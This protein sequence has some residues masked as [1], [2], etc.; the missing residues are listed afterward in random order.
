V[1][2]RAVL[3]SPD[4]LVRDGQKLIK[5]AEEDLA[6][7]LPTVHDIHLDPRNRPLQF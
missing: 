3:T 7:A 4:L 1:F 6:A 5:A 2:K